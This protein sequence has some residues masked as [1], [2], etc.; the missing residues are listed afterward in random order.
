MYFQEPNLIFF[1]LYNFM[2][3]SLS[4][5]GQQINLHKKHYWAYMSIAILIFSL[6]EGLRWGRGTDFNNYYLAYQEISKYKFNTDF[7]PFFTFLVLACNYL[8]LDYQSFVF[9]LSFILILSATIF[10][11]NHKDYLI[12]SLPLLAFYLFL[13]ENLMRWFLAFSFILI[14]LYYLER[15]KYLLYIAV[16]ILAFLTHYASIIPIIFIFIIFH[17]KKIIFP[18]LVALSIFCILLLTFKPNS[19]A[20][21][22]ELIQ[23]IQIANRFSG[24]QQDAES[25]FTGENLDMGRLSLSYILNC[26]YT[27]VVGYKVFHHTTK[28][29]EIY[30]YNLALIGSILAPA[31]NQIELFMRIN[32]LFYIFQFYIIAHCFYHVLNKKKKISWPY[33]LFTWIVLL[34]FIKMTVIS[35]PFKES[36]DSL[37]FI[38]DSNG[39]SMINN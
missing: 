34:N 29:N 14:S 21:I 8:S 9:L 5:I 13:A 37:L 27:I 26:I 6:T 18:P 11:Q 36:P 32:F 31:L 30:I 22:A 16:S 19:M 12:Y 20:F 25:W 4:I 28:R 35:M 2:L 1:L 24:Y 38:W 15:K 23:Q 33:K 3:V 39:K 17:I 7:E 10:L